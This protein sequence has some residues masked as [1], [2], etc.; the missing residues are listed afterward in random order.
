MDEKR[1]TTNDIVAM[2]LSAVRESYTY[3]FANSI[4]Y[5]KT[6]GIYRAVEDHT[7]ESHIQLCRGR[8]GIEEKDIKASIRYEVIEHIKSSTQISSS[9]FAARDHRNLTAFQNGW[10][11]VEAYMHGQKAE[12]R[13][14]GTEGEGVIFTQQIPHELVLA[15]ETETDAVAYLQ[16]QS[17]FI[18]NFLSK[19]VGESSVLLQ[20]QKIGYCFLRSNP[21]KRMFFEIGGADAGKTTFIKL[22]AA[23]LSSE[24]FCSV[25]M[26]ELSEN[27]QGAYL[28]NK[29]ANLC[30]DMPSDKVKSIGNLKMLTGESPYSS[31]RKHR[32]RIEFSNFAK[33]IFVA[34]VLPELKEKNDDAFFSRVIITSYPNSFERN[35]SFAAQLSEEQ[36]LVAT[37][38][39][40]M[41]SL[42]ALYKSGGF[43]ENKDIKEHWIRQIDNVYRFYA[44]AL[45]EGRLIR[46]AEGSVE[47]EAFYSEYVEWATAEALPAETKNSF[48]RS[49]SSFGIQIRQ[50]RLPSGQRG[51]VYAGI[52]KPTQAEIAARQRLLKPKPEAELQN[53]AVSENK[54]LDSTIPQPQPQ[55]APEHAEIGP[56]TK[57]TEPLSWDTIK[58]ALKTGTVLGHSFESVPAQFWQA[59]EA[60][61]QS[62]TIHE[63]K[64]G[65]WK[66]VSGSEA[67]SDES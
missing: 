19:L 42:R 6:G 13:P 22:L 65:V 10:L 46:D 45:D 47:K 27:F 36:N 60:M 40:A 48:T 24:N 18:Y 12:I 39:A 61:R 57:T 11:D 58:T 49:L 21:Y 28:F 2:L 64:P 34:N 53:Q 35:D 63:P 37:I 52:R 29:L 59:L 7:V 23:I 16:K 56:E 67:D 1:I 55:T 15:P 41:L 33:M 38:S 32:S 9:S 20:L 26:Q 44:E 54:P 25:R 14:F 30:D 51:Y 31:D 17:P 3:I 5:V 66:Y 62:G 8:A 43:V 4:L 50:A